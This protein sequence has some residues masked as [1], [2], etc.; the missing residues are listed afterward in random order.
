MS[1]AD[2]IPANWFLQNDCRQGLKFLLILQ[3]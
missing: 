1:L 2:K 3:Y